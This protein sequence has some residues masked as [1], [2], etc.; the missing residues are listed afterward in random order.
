MAEHTKQR[1]EPHQ[2]HHDLWVSVL[3]DHEHSNTYRI[4]DGSGH[5]T[6]EAC[7]AECDKRNALMIGDL[8]ALIERL[9]RELSE[10]KQRRIILDAEI[11]KP[12]N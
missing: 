4:R 11:A 6:K 12:S 10:A 7:L 9:E 2:M 3:R 5:I 8:N 1:W